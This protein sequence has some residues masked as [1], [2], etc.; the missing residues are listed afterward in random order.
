MTGHW[1]SPD[2]LSNKTDHHDMTEIL[3]K[4]PIIDRPLLVLNRDYQNAH[5]YLI[6][7]C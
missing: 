6:A 4:I 2:S 1:F 7:Y 5:I 3:E